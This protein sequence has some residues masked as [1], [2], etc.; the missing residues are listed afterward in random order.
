MT[1]TEANEGPNFVSGQCDTCR[2]EIGQSGPYS[3]GYTLARGRVITSGM[4]VGPDPNE[5]LDRLS[6]WSKQQGLEPLIFGCEESD[7]EALS[8]WDVTEVGRQPIFFASSDYNPELSGP[9]QPAEH[10][11][12]RSQ[13]RRALSKGVA[14]IKLEARELWRLLE[15][16]N[17][18]PILINRWQ[19][20]AMADLDFLVELSFSGSSDRRSFLITSA[21]R[22]R[23]LGLILMVSSRRGWLL[24]H[25]LLTPDAPNGT[26]ELA[27]CRL[28]SEHLQPGEQLSLGITPLYFALTREARSIEA[29]LQWV[30]QA[31]MDRLLTLSEP[32]YGFKRLHQFRSKLRPDRWESVYWAVPVKRRFG[33]LAAV[34]QAFAGGS[35]LGFG[36][37]TLKKQFQKFAF[38]SR[39]SF[40]PH[41][42]TFIIATLIL[43]IPILWNID[44]VPLFG[45]ALQSKV[46]AIYDLLLLILFVFQHRALKKKKRSVA[47][48]LLLGLVTADTV[49]AWI[50]TA[51]Y[52]GGLPDTHPLGTLVFIINTAPLCALFLVVMVK[53]AFEPIPFQR[54]ELLP[55]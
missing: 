25:Q 22:E 8:G 48:L 37:R 5:G 2:L 16:G 44:G 38:E 18:D 10:R 27:L 54:R 4:P 13:A 34:L 26:A 52:H 51:L 3:W 11:K 41:F 47:T 45:N 7:L 14:L 36:L 9:D 33:D 23:P 17:L 50:Q 30:P 32:L 53:L 6:A 31:I 19:H 29:I 12:L 39:E 24:E 43:W 28:L 20:L 40:L 35:F 15:S 55:T 49:L 42:S 46:W 1:P 21:N